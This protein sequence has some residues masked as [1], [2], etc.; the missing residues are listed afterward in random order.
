MSVRPTIGLAAVA[1]LVLGACSSSP[2]QTA[3]TLTSP[4]ARPAP[5]SSS[6]TASPTAGGA[7]TDTSTSSPPRSGR[8]VSIGDSYA[9]GYQPT[10]ANGGATNRNGFA[11]RVVTDA[12]AKGYRLTLTNF[13]CAGATTASAL[14]DPGCPPRNLG[15]GAKSYG[16]K[17]QAAA[18]AAYLAANRGKVALVTVI[19]GGNDITSCADSANAV[20]CVSAALVQVRANLTTLLS[21]LREAAG[22]TT[23][24]VGLTYPDI[25]LGDLLSKQA[26]QRSLGQQSV[27]AFK[28]LINPNLQATYEAAGASFLDVT[29]ATGAYGSM[30]ATTK[31]APYG[32]I[33]TPAAK[34][35]TLTYYCQYRDIHPRND[36]YALIAKLVV[37]EL[38]RT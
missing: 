28:S 33:P 31:L 5:T 20:S 23:R 27:L 24:I 34:I 11:Y 21:T 14:H 10:S 19:L 2:A 29:A 15:P 1:A 30:A 7:P 13:G 32:T 8:Y 9:A 12:A 17:T 4:P 22:P 16:R 18:A 38:A 6:A 3:P 35:C 25:F 36:G 37:D 26:D